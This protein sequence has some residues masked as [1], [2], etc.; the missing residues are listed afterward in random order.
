MYSPSRLCDLILAVTDA[1]EGSVRPDLAVLW[2][3]RYITTDYEG[4]AG[5]LSPARRGCRGAASSPAR[6]CLACVLSFAS[7]FLV[8]VRLCS[9]AYDLR[10]NL[11]VSRT[12]VSRLAF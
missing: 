3:A 8:R 6:Q 10:L 2:L 12:H 7:V 1:N 4:G 5:D 11:E 9:A